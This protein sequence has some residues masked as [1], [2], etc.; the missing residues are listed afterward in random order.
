M[1]PWYQ[2][3]IFYLRVIIVLVAPNVKFSTL[4]TISVQLI[5]TSIMEIEFVWIGASEILLVTNN[6]ETPLQMLCHLSWV[7]VKYRQYAQ[8]VSKISFLNGVYFCSFYMWCLTDSSNCLHIYDLLAIHA[9][10]WSLSP[11]FCAVMHSN[12]PNG[13]LASFLYHSKSLEGYFIWL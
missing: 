6:K 10:T 3:N 9:H 1:I 2:H 5:W 12:C 7:K 8:L 4:K 11:P 13:P